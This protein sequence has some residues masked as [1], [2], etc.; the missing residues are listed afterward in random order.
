MQI[1]RRTMNECKGKPQ[2]QKAVAIAICIKKRLDR[3]SMMRN[4]TINKLHT[5]TKISATTLN[6]YM[7]MLVEHNLVRFEGKNNQHL[8]VCK[9]ASN[10]NNRNICIDKFV[11]DSF[12]S[13][14]YS[15]RSF[16]ALIIQSHKDFIKRTIQIATDPKKGEDC[17]AARKLV[18]RLVKQGV[19]N[20]RY[21]RYKELGL[22]LKRIAKETGNCIRTAQRIMNFAIENNWAE[23]HK[24]VLQIWAKNVFYR[25]IQGFTFS[26]KNNIYKVCANSYVLNND[27]ASDLLNGNVRW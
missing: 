7:P 13:I 16:L 10:T 14:Y 12:Q 15:L 11:F 8:V 23:K 21:E 17:L 20:G 4:Y 19:L 3:S 5:L 9:L 27:I 1:K 22:G 2:L 26:T 6:K 25:D 24:N 18:K